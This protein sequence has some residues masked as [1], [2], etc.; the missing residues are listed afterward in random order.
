MMELQ[1]EIQAQGN[2]YFVDIVIDDWLI[3]EV[4]G[5]QKYLGDYGDSAAV[6]LAELKREKRLKNLGYEFLRVDWD[7]LRDNQFIPELNEYLTK[8]SRR[9][10]P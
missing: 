4:D 3:I 10:I 8:P 1:K 7:M 9:L 6:V 5:D 2:D